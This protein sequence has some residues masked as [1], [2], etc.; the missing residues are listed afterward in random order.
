MHTPTRARL[1]PLAALS[2][3]CLT[4]A[5][6]SQPAAAIPIVL[7]MRGSGYAHFDFGDELRDDLELNLNI[8]A[9]VKY[10][11]EAPSTFLPPGSIPSRPEL[12][13]Q[14]FSTTGSSFGVE[15]LIGPLVYTMPDVTIGITN[16][17]TP[18]FFGTC[19]TGTVFADRYFIYGGGSTGDF[20]AHFENCDDTAFD[21]SDYPLSSPPVIPLGS[22]PGEFVHIAADGTGAAVIHAGNGLQV[23]FALDEYRQRYP[24]P[25]PGTLPLL[26]TGLL[27]FLLFERRRRTMIAANATAK[28]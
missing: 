9:F 16:S 7:E 1:W 24:V 5:L 19:P 23:F 27:A 13:G 2:L 28:H 4:G 17:Q 11:D 8:T 14:N 3:S 20:S 22:G 18:D 26:A 12:Y 6:F 10:D 25:E 21:L 15:V